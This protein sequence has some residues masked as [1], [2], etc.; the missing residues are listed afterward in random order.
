M[1]FKKK[2][3][4]DPNSRK[5]II[6]ADDKS[7]H[8]M[9]LKDRL[10]K[11]HEVYPVQSIKSLFE[12]LDQT[13]PDIILIDISMPD[14]DD[15]ESVELL[16]SEIQSAG[17]I[18]IV[19][20]SS[21]VDKQSIQKGKNIGAA[22]MLV[23]PFSDNELLD[24]I[25]YHLNPV[26]PDS[27]KPIILAVDDDTGTLKS[28]AWLLERDYKVFTLPAPDKLRNI[29]KKTTPDLFLLDCTMEGYNGFDLIPVIRK[30]ADHKDTPIV[31]LTSDVTVDN[32]SKAISLGANDFLTKPID[33]TLLK[34]KIA[35]QF[36]HFMVL[37]RVRAFNNRNMG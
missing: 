4:Y 7:F 26:K 31:Y 19:F 5:N 35:A 34:E 25:E 36:K 18:P 27:Y 11:N 9:S 28:V 15:S 13:T 22:D 10:K 6:I 20:L 2:V 3:D 30:F 1:F 29:L 16:K 33:G 37:R 21:T 14:V 24:C 12:A 23:K 17:G 32:V 8:L